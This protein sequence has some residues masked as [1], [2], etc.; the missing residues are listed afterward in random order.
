MTKQPPK[1]RPP[2]RRGYVL[3]ALAFS[4]LLSS[5]GTD[6]HHQQ[7]PGRLQG[8]Y[9]NLPDAFPTRQIRALNGFWGT[10]GRSARPPKPYP[11]PDGACARYPKLNCPG[12]PGGT[13][14]PKGIRS[15]SGPQFRRR[16][17]L[18]GAV[19]PTLHASRPRSDTVGQVEGYNFTAG[20]D[21]PDPGLRTESNGMTLAGWPHVQ[22]A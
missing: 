19:G 18:P 16:F 20:R 2:H 10:S 7:P 21:I 15:Q 12:G 1:R 3:N 5:Q 9:S 14:L 11:T 4:T 8:N 22:L 17:R 13:D 6:A